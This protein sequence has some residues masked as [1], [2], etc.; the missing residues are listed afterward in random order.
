MQDGV[1]KCATAIG[2]N[3]DISGVKMHVNTCLDILK[4]LGRGK[5]EMSFSL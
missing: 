3:L 1:A 4:I 2:H 5:T